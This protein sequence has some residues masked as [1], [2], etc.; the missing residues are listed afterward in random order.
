MPHEE[1]SWSPRSLAVPMV[2]GRG[3]GLA[4]CGAA[5]WPHHLPGAAIC[6]QGSYLGR[7]R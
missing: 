6:G 7:R 1:C 2:G 3:P 5:H 4:A